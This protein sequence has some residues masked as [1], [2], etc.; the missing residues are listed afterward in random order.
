MGLNLILGLWN[1]PTMM[2][3]YYERALRK[4]NKVITV[5][6]QFGDAQSD[7]DVNPGQPLR[8][9]LSKIASPI[10]FYIQF[11]S[12]PDYFPPDLHL[13]DYPK[14]WYVYDLHL[15]LDEIA[16]SCY[17]FDLIFTYDEISKQQLI[18]KGVPRVEVLPFAADPEFYYRKYRHGKCKYQV[19]FSGTAWGS[20]ALRGREALLKKI[21][22][23]FDLKIEHRTL[24][25]KAVADFYQECQIVLNHAIKN[26]INMRVPETLLSGRPLLTP[27]VPGL[28]QM[29]K[30]QGHAMIYREENILEKISYMLSHPDE[31]EKMAQDG[32]A[33]A[34]EVLTYEK[35]AKTLCDFLKI[36][37]E[38]YKHGGRVPKNQFLAQAAQFN[39]HFFRFPGDAL[40]WLK[41]QLARKT[42]GL[43]KVLVLA[44]SALVLC[45][46]GLQKFKKTKYFQNKQ[47]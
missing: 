13:I 31:M 18:Q 28:E 10:D 5:G 12:K 20:E 21:G 17:L 42:G 25:G 43:Y 23:N 2:G 40:V 3:A 32:Q 38:T 1:S 24:A 34:L 27:E 15:H 41:G 29:I 46:L 22:E 30:P 6:P 35:R 11:Y 19:G 39:Y 37:L 9:V 8:V 47:G 33:Y 44:L 45:C 26:D 7:F 14:A 16:A 36:E 4:H